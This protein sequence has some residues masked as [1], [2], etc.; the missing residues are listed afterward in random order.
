MLIEDYF[1]EIQL[2]FQSSV[3]V[4]SLNIES[5]K[6]GFYE[7]FIRGNITFKDNSLLHFREFVYV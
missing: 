3:I 7:G 1:Q 4:K 5:D 6:R 2:L